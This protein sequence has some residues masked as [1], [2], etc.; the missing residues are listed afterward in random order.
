MSSEAFPT[1]CVV[2]VAKKTFKMLN[3]WSQPQEASEDCARNTDCGAR[4]KYNHTKLNLIEPITYIMT[5]F[6]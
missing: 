2:G 4:H 5:T 1:T 3:E 6:V